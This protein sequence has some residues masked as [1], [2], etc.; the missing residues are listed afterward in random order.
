MFPKSN[1]Y[2][3]SALGFIWNINL[4]QKTTNNISL[5]KLIW[6]KNYILVYIYICICIYMLNIYK[7]CPLCPVSRS[8]RFVLNTRIYVSSVS[9]V[10]VSCDLGV[11]A[12]F[13]SV[14]HLHYGLS[15]VVKWSSPVVFLDFRD[16]KLSFKSLMANQFYISF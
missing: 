8:L 11:F 15:V 14:L 13:T 16:L 4:H 2:E 12:I 1:S 10:L 6:T 3:L 5:H 7:M 9:R